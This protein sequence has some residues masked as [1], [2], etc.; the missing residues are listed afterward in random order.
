MFMENITSQDFNAAK[1]IIDLGL[2]KAAESLSFFMKETIT[3]KDVDFNISKEQFISIKNETSENNLYVL[4]TE[5]KGELKGICYLVFNE[6]EKDEICKV[7]LPPDIF[8]NPQ[9]LKNMEEPLLLEIDN[10]ISASVI[11]QISNKLK[12]KVY[13]DVPKMKLMKSEDLKNEII[14]Q[15]S[16]DK[17][18]IGFQTEFISS[19]SNFNPQFFWVL[20]SKFFECVKKLALEQAN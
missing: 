8:N 17:F 4:S 19:K 11:T 6:D 14:M 12:Q 7:A 10:I 16:P 5:I 2:N 1:E 13:G 15:M 18:I 3:L 9:K 20:D